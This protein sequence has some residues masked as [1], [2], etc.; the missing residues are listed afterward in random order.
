MRPGLV[1]GRGGETI[2][3]LAQILEEQFQLPSPQISV[4]EIEVPELNAHVVRI[5]NCPQL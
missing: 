5:T 3:A 2:R 4:A 1:I